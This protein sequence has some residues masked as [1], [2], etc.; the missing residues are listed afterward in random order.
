MFGMRYIELLMSRT[1]K[2]PMHPYAW[3]WLSTSITGGGFY[4]DYWGG[5]LISCLLLSPDEDHNP[6]NHPILY[7]TEMISRRHWYN[8]PWK[9]RDV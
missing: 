5:V 3:G 8:L 4:L 1:R 9:G 6:R 2:R 7:R